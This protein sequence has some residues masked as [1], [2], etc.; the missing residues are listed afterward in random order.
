[1]I[2]R[3]ENEM[4]RDGC[5]GRIL[6]VSSSNGSRMVGLNSSKKELLPQNGRDKKLQCKT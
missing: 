6:L 3:K 2:S 4:E 1:L 5:I